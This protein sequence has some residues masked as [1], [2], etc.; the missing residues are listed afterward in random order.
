[1]AERRFQANIIEWCD[2]VAVG[3]AAGIQNCPFAQLG[4]A[5]C[6]VFVS[7]ILFDPEFAVTFER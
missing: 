7:L 6:A 4:D 5:A 2:F 3:D 1:M